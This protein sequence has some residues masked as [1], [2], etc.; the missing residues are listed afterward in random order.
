[1]ACSL[2]FVLGVS[3]WALPRGAAQTA[4]PATP[5]VGAAPATPAAVADA[6]PVGAA[7]TAVPSNAVTTG[8]GS[9]NHL[10]SSGMPNPLVITGPAPVSGPA[11]LIPTT[12][13]GD[14]TLPPDLSALGPNRTTNTLPLY[15]YDVFQPARQIII[16]RRALLTSPPRRYSGSSDYGDYGYAPNGYGPNGFP[17]NGYAQNGYGGS[18]QGRYIGPGGYAAGPLIPGYPQAGGGQYGPD[19]NGGE[20]NGTDTPAGRAA[21]RQR[22]AG[23]G[24]FPGDAQQPNGDI[25]FPND[26]TYA[27]GATTNTLTGETADP[28]SILYGNVQASLP[29]NYRL[30][31]GDSLTIRYSA[32]ALDPRE[33]TAVVDTQGEIGVPGVGQISVTGRTV[34]QAEASLR[35]RLERLYRNVDVSIGLHQLRTISVTVSGAAYAAGT[36]TV[37]ATATAYNVLLAAGGPTADGSLRDIRILRDGRVA[38]ILDIYPLIGPAPARPG[39]RSGDITLQ[40]GDNIYIPAPLSRVSVRGEVRQQ[41]IYELAPRDTLRDVL[42]YAQGVKPSGVDQ[43]VHVD[44]VDRGIGRTLRDVNLR[45]A[46]EVAS[47]PL[48]DG[49]TVQVSSVR[50][51]LTNRVTVEGAVDQPGDYALTP[52]MRVVDLLQ[53]A[54]GPLYDAYLDRADLTRLNRDNTTTLQSISIARALDGDPA[55]NVLLDRFD[56]LRLY[57]RQEVNYLGRRV[58]TVRGAVQR[59]GIYTQS[60]G[61]RVSN[62]LLESGGPLPDAYQNRAVLLHQRGDGTYAY[63][64]VNLRAVLGGDAAQDQPIQDNDV[65]AVYRIGE[66]HFTP[67]HTVKVLGN[68]VAPGLYARGEGMRLTDLL[69]VAGAY[70]PGGGTRVTL[71]NARRSES[72]AAS[73]VAAGDDPVLQ[74]GDVVAVQGDGTIKDHPSVVTVTGKVNRPGPIIISSRLRL[75]DA[76]RAA[77]GLGLE[78][79][80]QG[81]EFTRTSDA[82]ATASQLSLAAVISQMSDMLNLTAYERERA[83]ANLALIQAAGAAAV[84]GATGGLGGL[85]GGGATAGAAGSASGPLV[86]SLPLNN[87]VSPARLLTPSQ[88]QPNGSVAIRLAEALKHPGGPEDVL[89]KDGDTVVIPEMPTTV[90]VIGAV[91]SARGVLF[92]PGQ[93][94][95]YY[96][97]R[98]GDYT[99]DAAHDAIEIIHA[100]GGL[101]P[102][103]KA[104]ALQPGDLILVPTKVLAAKISQSGNGFASFFQGLLGSALSFKLLTSVFGL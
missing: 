52:G 99:P 98:A 70:R 97:Q 92:K 17:T 2:L 83:K 60:D 57:S 40:P 89:L 87:T 64:Y 23:G 1:M 30:Q 75:S 96:V 53:R 74:D 33:F 85:A 101:I 41:A 12:A 19:P 43:T 18:G 79:F 61:M 77:G 16:A 6:P 58:V 63:D 91:Y 103:G 95:D 54:R 66:A 72:A 93:S 82:L 81:A 37:P 21:S 38:G 44:T 86:S 46:A 25:Q 35:Q 50:A 78:A 80:P 28:A 65:L 14:Y 27:R 45:N 71:A 15:G 3:A 88:L 29:P 42:V 4:A 34:T 9:T 47:L 10:D 67:D 24:A 22:V 102:A 68:V 13:P 49:D 73:L 48:Y 84:N 39:R 31:P 62:L 69:K 100:G 56:R 8:S 11:A 59:P 76:V 36:Y 7:A 5:A 20:A 32:L 55:Q 94:V 90:Q 51:I 26:A 104:G